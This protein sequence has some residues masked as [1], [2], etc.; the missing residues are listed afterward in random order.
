MLRVSFAFTKSVLFVLIMESAIS[1]AFAAD[2]YPA[3]TGSSVSMHRRPDPRQSP[4]L[5]KQV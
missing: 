3:M 2:W 5:Q 4:F 1:T